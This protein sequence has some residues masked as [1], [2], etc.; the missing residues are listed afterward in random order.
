LTQTATG[1][2]SGC[3]HSSS[4]RKPA[5][6][7]PTG[8]SFENQLSRVRYGMTKRVRPGPHTGDT[9]SSTAG[10]LPPPE[11]VEEV[12]EAPR[13]TGSARHRPTDAPTT[14]RVPTAYH[15]T[16]PPAAKC[17]SVPMGQESR[18]RGRRSSSAT[19]CRRSS[20]APGRATPTGTGSQ[21]LGRTVPAPG[22]SAAKDSQ[23]VTRPRCT[24]V[25]AARR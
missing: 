21:A 7:C 3:R 23:G 1:P 5:H 18:A 25:K 15:E 14:E 10:R 20:R 9:A 8:H 16:F 6:Q 2:S 11:L 22:R 4:P 19:G 13:G 17:C 24:T 12:L